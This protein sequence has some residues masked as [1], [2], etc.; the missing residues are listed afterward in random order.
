MKK[1]FVEPDIQMMKL[2]LRENIASSGGCSWP[3]FLFAGY[4]GLLH[5][6][7]DQAQVERDYYAMKANNDLVNV[8]PFLRSYGSCIIW[9][10]P[11]NN[12]A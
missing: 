11:L 1:F 5:S 12:E 8:I 4:G 2:N 3:V 10:S 7:Y 6:A 9:L